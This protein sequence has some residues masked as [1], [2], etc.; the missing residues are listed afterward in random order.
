VVISILLEQA[1]A[2]DPQIFLDQPSKS[3]FARATA[4]SNANNHDFN[5]LLFVSVRNALVLATDEKS[6]GPSENAHVWSSSIKRTANSV[7][8]K[9]ELKNATASW[10]TPTKL[11]RK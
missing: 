9:E 10:A 3:G 8:Q 6:H 4:S 2:F 5:R 11:T 7:P 1:T